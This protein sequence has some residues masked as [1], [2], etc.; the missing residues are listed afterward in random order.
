M[1][2]AL[3]LTAALVMA[4]G[5]V[6]AAQTEPID[7]LGSLM[8]VVE[9]LSDAGEEDPVVIQAEYGLQAVALRDILLDTVPDDCYALSYAAAWAVYTDLMHLGAAETAVEAR[10]GGDWLFE[11]I[12]GIMDGYACAP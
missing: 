1:L 4:T 5:G 11:D 9:A 8:P 3:A 6:A 7:Y 2:K 10:T 12:S